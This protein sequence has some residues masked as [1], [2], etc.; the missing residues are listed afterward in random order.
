MKKLLRDNSGMALI[1]TVSIISLIVALTLQFNTSM[2]SNLHAAANLSD[3][4][5][6]GCIARSGFNGALAVLYEDASSGDVDTLREPWAHARIISENSASLFDEG[7]FLLE[8]TDLSG[9][10]QINQLVHQNGNYND[11]QKVSLCGSWGSQ[12]LI[13]ILKRW[14]I[15]QMP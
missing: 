12:N 2:R 9:R 4:I 10:I 5:K 3:G 13:L 11:T 15:L 8:I 6:L 1:L 14:K 7:R